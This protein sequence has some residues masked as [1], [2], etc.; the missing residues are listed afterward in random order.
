VRLEGGPGG[1]GLA[2]GRSL[3]RAGQRGTAGAKLAAGGG[4]TRPALG[5]GGGRRLDDR[6]KKMM[7]RLGGGRG[8]G[9]MRRWRN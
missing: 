2:V 3:S 9:G 6:A 8:W 7:G 4:G 5:G 1:G